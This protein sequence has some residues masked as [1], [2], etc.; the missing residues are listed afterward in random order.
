MRTAHAAPVAS[1]AFAAALALCAP[2]A[3]RASAAD[4]ALLA[5]S[6]YTLDTTPGV[7]HVR[8]G[9]VGSARFAVKPKPGAHVSP[10]APV[11]VLLSSGGSVDFPKVKLTRADSKPTA[12]QGVE[13]LLP[14]NAKTLGAETVKADVTFYICVKDLCARQQ[15]SLNFAVAI[16]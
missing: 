4:E 5:A 16:E 13:V 12:E 2:Q 7:I 10:D 9:A 3:A 11:L 15:K 8:K 1:A 6:A 14:F